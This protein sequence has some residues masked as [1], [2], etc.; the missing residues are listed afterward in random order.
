MEPICC[1]LSQSDVVIAS[2]TYYARRACPVSDASNTLNERRYARC[3]FARSKSSLRSFSPFKRTTGLCLRAL[4]R[5]MIRPDARYVRRRLF[6]E[7]L[8]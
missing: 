1:V 6:G 3:S 5:V 2:S 4:Q 8:E 7:G